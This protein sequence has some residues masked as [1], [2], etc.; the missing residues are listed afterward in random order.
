MPVQY[1]GQHQDY[2][3]IQRDGWKYIEKAGVVVAG[4]FSEVSIKVVENPSGYM[5][6]AYRPDTDEGHILEEIVNEGHSRVRN[7]YW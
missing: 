1:V 4:G 2:S 6:Q 7:S 3:V 5:V